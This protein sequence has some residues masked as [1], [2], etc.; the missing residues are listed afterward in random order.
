MVSATHWSMPISA[1]VPTAF[2]ERTASKWLLSHVPVVLARECFSRLS[3]CMIDCPCFL[4]TSNNGT[5]TIVSSTGFQCSC[6]FGYTGPQCELTINA[7][8]SNPCRFGTCQQLL[9]GYY[10]CQ[11]SPGYTGF[12]CQTETNECQSFPC[13]NNGT[14]LDLINAFNCTCPIGFTGLHS[15]GTHS[16]LLHWITLQVLNVNRVVSSVVRARVWIMERAQWP[17][18]VINAPAHPVYLELVAKW[19]SMNVPHR[20]VRMLAFVSN[21]FW[22]VMIA[23]VQP[24]RRSELTFNCRSTHLISLQ[25][26]HRR[27]LW[28]NA[29][30][31]YIGRVLE[32]WQLYSDQCNNGGVFLCSWFY[33]SPVSESDQHLFECTLY[34]WNLYSTGQRIS[35]LLFSRLYRPEVCSW[36]LPPGWARI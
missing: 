35:M 30:S 6:L 5:C 29:R 34:Q 22:T 26:I 18:S 9:P 32:Q 20:R 11:C 33:W 3:L 14:C 25:R 23:F 36:V 24:V 31:V 2:K 7:C 12:N 8:T 27:Q 13:L 1:D 15:I 19:I 16:I 17:V 4:L 21:A 10:Y 28:D